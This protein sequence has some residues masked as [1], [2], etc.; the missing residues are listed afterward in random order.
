MFYHNSRFN[1]KLADQSPD[2]IA[3]AILQPSVRAYPTLLGKR[4]S[5]IPEKQ[6]SY[7]RQRLFDPQLYLADI[8]KLVAGDVIVNLG[9]YPW[10]QCA[11]VAFEAKGAKGGARQWKREQAKAIRDSWRGAPATDAD[12]IAVCARAAVQFQLAIGCEVI[13]LPSPMTRAPGSYAA[14]AQWMEAGAAACRTLNVRVP[15][16][17]TVAIA[18]SA[19]RHMRPGDSPLLQTVTAHVAACRGIAGAYIVLAQDAEDGYVCRNPDTLLSLL[20]LTDDLV[21]GAGL[22]V[23]VNYMGTFGA[24]AAAVGAKIWSSGYYRSQRRLRT[25]D[26]EDSSGR[27]LPRYYSTRLLGDVGVEKELDLVAA[28]AVG[29]RVLVDTEA[30]RM[31][32]QVLRSGGRV[33]DVPQWQYRSTNVT[34]AMAHYNQ[35]MHHL[36][37]ALDAHTPAER[38]E[39]MQRRLD[40]A[41]A[42]AYSVREVITDERRT[43]GHTDVTSQHIWQDVFNA[44]RQ[45]AN[46]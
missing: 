14:E 28:H 27:Q 19:L 33:A 44:W 2:D 29:D 18:D 34:A 8:N 16:L 6:Y 31:L 11:H 5:L 42:L 3:G 30:S 38:I 17:A 22:D 35:S 21:R 32:N 20:L 43:T 37:V 39:S 13:I 1:F 12:D 26:M 10:F 41:A 46:R 40:R 15:V 9:T 23:V 7:L 4:G 45:H 25:S 24:V 36:G